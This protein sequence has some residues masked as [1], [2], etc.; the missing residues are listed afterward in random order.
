MGYHILEPIRGTQE[1][2]WIPIWKRLGI[3]HDLPVVPRD[4]AIPPNKL[5][6][7]VIKTVNADGTTTREIMERV[8]WEVYEPY[9]PDTTEGY[10]GPPPSDEA[11]QNAARGGRDALDI[12]GTLPIP[13][14]FAQEHDLVLDEYLECF[15]LKVQSSE[16]NAWCSVYPSMQKSPSAGDPEFDSGEVMA[17]VTHRDVQFE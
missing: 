13:P 9:S 12:A 2:P 5:H 3:D 17:S 4:A 14:A 6:L 10:R 15:I 1:E 8:E 11:F 7:I 16:S